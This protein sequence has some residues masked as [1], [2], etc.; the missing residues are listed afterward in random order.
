M[1]A[2]RVPLARPVFVTHL[3]T[4][5]PLYKP[6]E[7][8]RFRSLTLDR[9]SFLPPANDMHLQFKLRNP[10]GA[11]IPLDD[12]NGRVMIG[13][14]P[15]MGP[16]GKPLRGIG[17]GE[18]DLGPDAP[19]GEYTLEVVEIQ[20]RGRE[21]VLDTRKFLVNKY[22]ADVFEKKLEF[23]GKSYGPG[24]TIQARVEVSRTA[25]GPMKSAQ[26]DVIA[27]LNDGSKEGRKLFATDNA[28]FQLVTDQASRQTKTVL[29]VR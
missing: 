3:V 9:A 5:K 15:V 6:G 10:S 14:K 25:G 13:L 18:Y 22:V 29:N 8:V 28:A 27:R 23:D 2:E 11:L 12:G 19:G 7:I 16:D 1:L 26:A 21:V 24:D 4:D 20:D 17:T